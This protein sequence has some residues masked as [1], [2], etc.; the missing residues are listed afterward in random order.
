MAIKE[1]K[2]GRV[3]KK[4]ISKFE[5]DIEN[6]ISGTKIICNQLKF[7]ILNPKN[8]KLEYKVFYKN[9]SNGRLKYIVITPRKK[10]REIY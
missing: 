8:W 5:R 9:E 7:G 1:S 6:A 2:G 3:S 10:P 4:N